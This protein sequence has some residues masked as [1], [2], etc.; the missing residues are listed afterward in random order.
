VLD[1]ILFMAIT[2]ISLILALKYK[3]TFFLAIPF[4]SIFIYF[5]IQIVLVPAPFWETVKFIFSLT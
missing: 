5:F 2:A 1:F 4:L 3:K